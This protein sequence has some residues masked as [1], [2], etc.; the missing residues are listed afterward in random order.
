MEK[1]PIIAVTDLNCDTGT[2]AEQNGYGFWCPSN[3]V[4]A[5]TSIVNKTL[6]SDLSKM[7]EKAYQYYL[8]NYTVKHT[9]DIICKHINR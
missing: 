3:S 8:E 7:G 2:I 5:F 1:K 4:E 6:S 9:Y